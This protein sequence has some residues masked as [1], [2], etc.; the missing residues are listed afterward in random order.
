MPDVR[1]SQPS[2]ARTSPR[3]SQSLASAAAPL[4]R[5]SRLARFWELH[6]KTLYVWIREGRLAAVRTPGDQFRL[7]PADVRAFAESAGLPVPPFILAAPRC[8]HAAAS[9]GTW[10][11]ALRRALKDAEVAL[12]V[13]ER[14]LDAV[15]AAV[16]TPPALLT[17]DAGLGGLDL[18]EAVRALRRRE[19]TARLPVVIVNV[20][21]AARADA[22]LRAGATNAHVKGKE[23]DALS[24]IARILGG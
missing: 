5:P 19:A 10:L 11:R 12:D 4:V 21:S 17:L 16:A 3:P 2:T 13:H 9:A 7:R 20:A 15:L 14:S 18:D 23:K 22:L 8:A 24:E 1:A 6:P